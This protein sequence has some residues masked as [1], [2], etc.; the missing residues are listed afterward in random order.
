MIYGSQNSYS[1]DSPIKYD[2]FSQIKVPNYRFTDLVQ[3]C[4]TYSLDV[5]VT[6][7]LIWNQSI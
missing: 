1:S 7:V 2:A 6:V 4:S 5:N 3:I